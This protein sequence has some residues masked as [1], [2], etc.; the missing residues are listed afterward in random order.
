METAIITSFQSGSSSLGSGSMKITL[1]TAN[2]LIAES[3]IKLGATQVGM[4]CKRNCAKGDHR[5]SYVILSVPPVY[6]KFLR[7]SFPE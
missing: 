7:M 6:L 1:T 5:Y 4:N 2:I 3:V